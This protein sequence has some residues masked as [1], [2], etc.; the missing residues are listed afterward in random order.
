MKKLYT[1]LL[2]FFACSMMSAQITL[3]V[4]GE[5]VKSGSTYTKVYGQE[6]IEDKIPGMPQFGQTCGLY[7]KVLL[8][9]AK[10]QD[11]TLTITNKN[12]AEGVSNCGFGL[13]ESLDA[14]NNYFSQKV[15]KMEAGKAE[16]LL[17]DVVHNTPATAPYE[18]ELLIDAY[19]TEDSQR[20]TATIVL[21]YDPEAAN[22]VSSVHATNSKA[23]LYT[24]SGQ[25]VRQASK[26]GIY[27]QN[28]RK[29]IR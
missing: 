14:S 15:G 17:I 16:D 28:G 19:G 25:A 24:L 20:C 6:V 1:L 5:T 4:D 18:V 3:T 9:S 21:R 22:S 27:I 10:T 23:P 7:P 12:Q 2:S 29:V 8:T 26:K 13:C 11:V